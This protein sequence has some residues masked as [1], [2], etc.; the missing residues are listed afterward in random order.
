M[1]GNGKIDWFQGSTLPKIPI[2]WMKFSNKSCWDFNFLEKI[3]CAHMS[4][5]S[6]TVARGFERLPCLKYYNVQKWGN[7]LTLRLNTAKNTDYMK[8]VWRGQFFKGHI[9][10]YLKR[11]CMGG[12]WFKSRG[13]RW[14]ARH[15][16]T[17]FTAVTWEKITLHKN[18]LY[19][20]RSSYY[21]L[22]KYFFAMKSL[23]FRTFT[24]SSVKWFEAWDSEI[25]LVK[26]PQQHE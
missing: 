5:S 14:L 24:A 22:I 26:W 15:P 1:Y 16:W 21:F 8:K 10:N 13:Y 23:W 11:H 12:G 25:C 4:I 18:Y 20:F 17:C 19:T 3:Y 6:W 2:I 7:R 9:Y